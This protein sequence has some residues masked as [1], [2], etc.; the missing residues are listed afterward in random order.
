MMPVSSAR[1]ST[2][3]KKAASRNLREAA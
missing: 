3:E 1:K 2:L